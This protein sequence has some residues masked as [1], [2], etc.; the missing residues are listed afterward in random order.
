MNYLFKTHGISEFIP[1]LTVI[2]QLFCGLSFTIKVKYSL[3]KGG[4]QSV[5]PQFNLESTG[6]CLI[7]K[8]CTV[9]LTFFF[10]SAQP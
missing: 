9:I 4:E 5:D 8:F 6:K 3:K 7:L 10:S 1:Y 2:W